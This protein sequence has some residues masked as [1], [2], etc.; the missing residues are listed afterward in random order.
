MAKFLL[1]SL[2]AA[3]IWLA[4]GI[5]GI[6]GAA[7][8]VHTLYASTF[9]LIW[10]IALPLIS[11]IIGS[12]RTTASVPS[13]KA[14]CYFSVILIF[15]MMF[16]LIWFA[17]RLLS[18]QLLIIACSAIVILSIC[19]SLFGASLYRAYITLNPPPDDLG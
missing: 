8:I 3:A 16:L 6:W 11:S 4:A 13:L 18:L 10:L 9:V 19:G 7:N 17:P 14:G 15:L 2:A 5:A 1:N 12:W